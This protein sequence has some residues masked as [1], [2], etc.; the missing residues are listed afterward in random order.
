MIR[1]QNSLSNFHNYFQLSTSGPWRRLGSTKL[2]D[3]SMVQVSEKHTSGVLNSQ[4]HTDDLTSRIHV[5]AIASN[6]DALY[7]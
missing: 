7:R 6:G 4:D 2:I 5:W 3:I 1:V